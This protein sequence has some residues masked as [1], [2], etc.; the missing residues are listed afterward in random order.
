MIPIEM[1]FDRY[2]EKYGDDDRFTFV[3]FEDRGHNYVFCSE[4]RRKY[5]E[6]Y[7]VVAEAYSERVGEMTE[8]MRAAYYEENFDKHKGYELDEQL[9]LQMLEFY[10]SSLE[11]NTP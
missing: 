6:E 11:R 9:M 5:V 7:N 2:Y 10:N 1:S 8:E 3:R 4:A